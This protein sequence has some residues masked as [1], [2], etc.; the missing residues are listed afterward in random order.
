MARVDW[1]AHLLRSLVLAAPRRVA[2][3]RAADDQCVRT[4]LATLEAH[5]NRLAHRVLEQV[6]GAPAFRL[7]GIL[8]GMQRLLTVD[9][10]P[11]LTVDDISK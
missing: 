3:R 11:V 8:A 1:I 4:L 9:G 6:P 7:R 2:G 10:Y 5:Y